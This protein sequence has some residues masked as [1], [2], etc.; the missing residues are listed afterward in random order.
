MILDCNFGFNWT[1]TDKST[2]NQVTK[3]AVM[4]GI[5][6]KGKQSPIPVRASPVYTNQVMTITQIVLMMK[7]VLVMRLKMSK[8]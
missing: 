7:I 1:T 5:T 4:L 8:D 6:V 2:V 3:Q